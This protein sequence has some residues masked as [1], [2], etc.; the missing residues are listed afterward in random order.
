MRSLFT[1]LISLFLFSSC[2]NTAEEPIEEQKSRVTVD[3]STF[4]VDVEDMSRGSDDP[5]TL[6]DVAKR[7]SFA[8]FKADG[9]TPVT[10]TTIHQVKSDDVN[11]FGKV[12]LEL[13]SGSYQIVAVAHNGTDVVNIH[14]VASATLPGTTFTDTFVG[15]YTLNVI[16]NDCSFNMPLHRITSAFFLNL[17]D[18]PPAIAKRMEIVLNNGGTAPTQLKINP[19]TGLAEDNWVQTSSFTMTEIIDGT[20]DLVYYIG[21][22]SPTKVLVRATAYDSDNKQVMRRPFADVPLTPNKKTRATGAFFNSSG[23]ASF[24]ITSDWD[25]DDDEI[26]Y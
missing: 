23:S 12:Q 11:G 4:Q 24:T 10:G 22:S 19:S 25:S 8:V 20:P 16:S 13:R 3:F 21:K 1:F 26:E 5:L 18:E 2:T 17:T 15:V 9:S 7:L 6:A 14:T